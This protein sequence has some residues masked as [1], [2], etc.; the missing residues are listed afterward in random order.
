MNLAPVV[1]F[2]F[3]RSDLLK[4]TL[5]SLKTNPLANET[6][7]YIFIDGPRND[8]DTDKI[9]QVKQ[10]AIDFTGFKEKII[11]TSTFNQGLAKS[12]ISGVTK[13][14][15][16]YGKV[17]VVEDDLYVSKSFLTYMNALLTTYENDERI[18]QVSGFG[19]KINVPSGYKYDVYL[20]NRAHSW[21][22]GTWKDRWDTVDWEVK[23]YN[24]LMHDKTK[25]KAF[26]KGG[27]DLYGMLKGFMQGKNNSWYIRF[28]YSMFLQNRYGVSPIKSLVINDGF[29]PESTHCN[30]Y[31]RYKI[32]FLNEYK[33][34]FS[35]PPKIEWDSRINKQAKKYWSI[36]YR[37]HGKIMTLLIKMKRII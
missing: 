36:P 31:N 37:I 1:V 15:N 4:N 33:Q 23:D 13:I 14:I 22:W 35:I 34:E 24:N 20:N 32:D 26:N 21:T 28:T 25:Q 7:L 17:I 29:R 3:N 2:A 8:A 6:N 30:V 11:F 10:I 16:K 27:S 19:V 5:D 18:F 9:N 12:I